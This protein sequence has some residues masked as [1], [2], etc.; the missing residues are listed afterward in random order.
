[1]S[2]ER[3]ELNPLLNSPLQGLVARLGIKIR[4]L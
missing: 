3:G 4:L 2:L 1:L